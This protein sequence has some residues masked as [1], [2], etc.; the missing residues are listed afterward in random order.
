MKA[1]FLAS[2]VPEAARAMQGWLDAGHEIAAV[3]RPELKRQGTRH[4]DGRLALYAPRWSSSALTRREN[5]PVHVVPRLSRWEG[6]LDAARAVGADVLVSVYFPF[7]VPQDLLDLYGERAVN[8]HPAPLPRYRGPSPFYAM[9][10]DRSI[11][12]D[13]AL[14]LHVM[15][16]G[17][18]EGAI[19]AAE[20]IAFPPDHSLPRYRLGAARAAYKLMRE[21]LPAFIDGKLV[22]R[23]QD[24]AI[25]T[26]I[27]F[28]QID[29]A[30]DTSMTVDEIRWRCQA[31]APSRPLPIR[32]HAKLKVAHFSRVLG[33]PTG[34]PTS[35]G[36]FTVDMDCR[37]GRVR[38]SRKMP[39]MSPQRK[40]REVLMHIYEPA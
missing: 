13:G 21:N 19:I 39:W 11:L 34:Q 4:R 30:L 36:R 24:T 40:L 33:P 32:D 26:Y 9:M 35:V 31:I 2:Y 6:R 25:A 15:S 22:T 28:D 16:A 37:D 12:T 18:D 10:L 5:I 29:I 27:G 8:L 3:W 17:L 7:V 14:T 23:E 20:P 38:L 1:L